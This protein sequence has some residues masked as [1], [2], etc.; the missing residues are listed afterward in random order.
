[1]RADRCPARVLISSEALC[2]VVLRTRDQTGAQIAS[3]WSAGAV[4]SERTGT[5]TRFTAGQVPP[6]SRVSRDSLRYALCSSVCRCGWS[7]LVC[8]CYWKQVDHGCVCVC[9]LFIKRAFC[10]SGAHQHSGYNSFPVDTDAHKDSH[11]KLTLNVR[12]NCS[13][14]FH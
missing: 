14:I 5:H 6:G 2:A 13:G 3:A 1:M 7:V 9:E 12:F 4:C 8:S 10:E 11:S